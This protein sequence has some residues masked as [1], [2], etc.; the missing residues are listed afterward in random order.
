MSNLF[1]KE[2]LS[3][4]NQNQQHSFKKGSLWILTGGTGGGGWE[5]RWTNLSFLLFIS[6]Q[7]TN[8]TPGI[9]KKK[10]SQRPKGKRSRGERRRTPSPGPPRPAAAQARCGRTPPDTHSAA[11]ATS[12][13]SR[14]SPAPRPAWTLRFWF[15]SGTASL[16]TRPQATPSSRPK[17]PRRAPGVPAATSAGVAASFPP[18]PPPP[19]PPLRSPGLP[20]RTAACSGR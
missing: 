6:F 3:S 20:T 19:P 18:E 7:T 16:T 2:Y 12:P 17:A 11:E 14:T 15:S 1:P 5:Q 13:S 8:I 4:S 10:K 9:K